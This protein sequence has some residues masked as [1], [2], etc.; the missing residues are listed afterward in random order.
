MTKFVLKFMDIFFTYSN[1]VEFAHMSVLAFFNEVAHIF[2]LLSMHL[3]KCL[4]KYRSLVQTLELN[5]VTVE[6]K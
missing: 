2:L 3:A 6:K 4:S 1:V 5:E